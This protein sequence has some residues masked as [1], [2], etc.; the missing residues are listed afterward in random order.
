[1]ALLTMHGITKTF[2]I[3]RALSN[4]DLTLDAGEV[5]GL[6]GENGAGKSTLIKTLA[7]AHQPD[8]GTI[9]IHDKPVV[10]R[11]PADSIAASIAIIY[12]ELTMV[13]EL[14]IAE[15]LFLGHVPSAGG[16][17]NRSDMYRRAGELLKTLDLTLD[18]RTPV[19]QLSIGYQQMIEIGRAINRQARILVMDEPTSSLSRQESILLLKFVRRLK[20]QGI[21]I[22]YISHHI[23]EVFEVCD[24][25]MVMRDGRVVGDRPTHEWTNDTLVETM[26]NHSI[27]N[28]FPYE[29]R[30][31]GDVVLTVQHLHI[32]PLV[33][34][35]SF[36][37]RRGEIVGIAGTVG[38][39]RS[40][41]LKAIFGAL[42]YQSG[43]IRWQG[44]ALHVRRP[45]HAIEKKIALVPGDRKTE[46]LMLD[47]SIEDN[48]ALSVLKRISHAGWVDMRQK[49][50]LAMDGIQQFNVKARSG[51]TMA[52]RYLS[53]GNQQ[54]VVFARTSE[55]RPQLFL[56][57]EPTRGV[58][59]G[60]KVEIYS[61]IMQMA[62]EGCT[63]LLSSSEF[64]EL[65]GLSDRIIIVNSGHVVGN[66]LRDEATH[67]K[68]LS[69]STGERVAETSAELS[70]GR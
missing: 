14:S 29:P 49:R 58:D 3:N 54:K 12:Q 42:P 22:I 25:T 27:D 60:A 38:S 8:A 15:N 11:S 10:M 17:V 45:E 34:D 18:P 46:G 35:I 30:A 2:G 28:Y 31:L 64:P 70:T 57:D 66:L 4:V 37:A 7:G 55:T 9:E 63:I 19:G 50:A 23:E 21:G 65:L 13:P 43:E 1:M 62:Q 56:L 6:V 26:V 44:E 32:A 53:G 33:E 59:I 61:K 40:E 51:P 24:R 5:L 67:E 41:V 39:G 69:L 52:P 48:I 16:W 36:D 68:L 47:A 20:E